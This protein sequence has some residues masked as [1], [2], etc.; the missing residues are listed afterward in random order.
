MGCKDATALWHEPP[1]HTVLGEEQRRG[2]FWFH[3]MHDLV[4]L[5]PRVEEPPWEALE[6]LV[7][8]FYCRF[9]T[10]PYGIAAGPIQIITEEMARFPTVAFAHWITQQPVAALQR[11]LEPNGGSFEAD[12]V[13]IQAFLEPVTRWPLPA[14]ARELLPPPGAKTLDAAVRLSP[15]YREARAP[16]DV[17]P[18]TELEVSA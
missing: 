18:A 10:Q 6:Y 9:A 13:Q 17:R 2:S 1:S 12:A 8:R 14:E 7:D 4:P 3:C 5:L 15:L 11:L 16:A